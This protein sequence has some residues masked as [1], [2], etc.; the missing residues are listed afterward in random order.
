MACFVAGTTGF[1]IN[2]F[3]IDGTQGWWMQVHAAFKVDG[4]RQL[5][6]LAPGSK[7]PCGLELS[8]PLLHHSQ[9][10]HSIAFVTV[11]CYTRHISAFVDGASRFSGVH[12]TVTSR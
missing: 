9:T 12:S 8:P 10:A 2:R 1:L 3:R 7:W 11:A 6:A 4:C 5:E